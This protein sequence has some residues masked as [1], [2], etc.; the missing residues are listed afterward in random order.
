[1][2]PL[3][4]GM[5]EWI[6]MLNV[7]TK[8]RRI[9]GFD[10][11]ITERTRELRAKRFSVSVILKCARRAHLQTTPSKTISG[12]LQLLKN[13]V[14]WVLC[15]VLSKRARKRI[16]H[17]YWFLISD[18]RIFLSLPTVTATRA[19]CLCV[20]KIRWYEKGEKKLKLFTVLG[21]IRPYTCSEKLWPVN[22][23]P[24]NAAL[25]CFLG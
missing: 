24:E 22:L 12:V 17:S 14:R 8:F 25:A 1:M 11:L 20:E 18:V 6:L 3:V 13:Y 5:L 16:L 4:Y 7:H 10:E 23:V 2:K 15:F 19:R 9:S 21:S